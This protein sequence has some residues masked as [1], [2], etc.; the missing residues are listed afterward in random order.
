MSSDLK[1]G[2][3]SVL[4][5]LS[6][7]ELPR[8]QNICTRCPLELRMKNTKANEY[9]TIRCDGVDEMEL[10]DFANIASQVIAC[11]NK[12]AGTNLGVSSSPIYLTVY[13]KDIQADLTLIDLPGIVSKSFLF[14]S[15]RDIVFHQYCTGITRNAVG[16]QPENIYENIVDLVTRYIEEPTSIVLHVIPSSED[17]TNSESM[18]ISRKHDPN[19]KFHQ[20]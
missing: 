19:G 10:N 15:Q 7:I 6:G 13:K 17:F 9:A 1:A 18:K 16:D 3:S 2:K 5:A 12:L 8:G 4:E 20:H 14:F 11:T